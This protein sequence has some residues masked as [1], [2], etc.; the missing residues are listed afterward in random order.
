MCDL[1]AEAESDQGQF[2]P[3]HKYAIMEGAIKKYLKLKKKG[4]THRCVFGRNTADVNE[5]A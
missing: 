4:K 5:I 2:L 3:Q 1:E